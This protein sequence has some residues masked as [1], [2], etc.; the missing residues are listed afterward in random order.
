MRANAA[1][2]EVELYLERTTTNLYQWQQQ[3]R[4]CEKE[5]V[6]H[7]GPP[8]ANGPPHMGHVLNKVLKDIINRNQVLSG[9]RVQYIPGWDCHG[10]PIEL[11]A[12]KECRRTLEADGASKAA[13]ALEIREIARACALEAIGVQKE[14]FKRWG[15]MADWDLR[16]ASSPNIQKIYRTLDPEYEAMQLEVLASMVSRGCI[17]RGFRPVY[18][19]PSSR[20]ALAEA[21]LEYVDA[22]VSSAVHC[23]FRLRKSGNER[24]NSLVEQYPGVSVVIWTTTPW[25]LPANMA[26]CVHPSLSY[27]V[28]HVPDHDRYYMVAEELVD[29]FSVALEVGHMLASSH[30]RTVTQQRAELTADL[31]FSALASPVKICRHLFP[32]CRRGRMRSHRQWWRRCPARTSWGAP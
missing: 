12:L 10:L 11:K 8:Y 16:Y 15:V 7:D 29:D 2:R 25:T 21:E 28:L 27:V 4:Q 5:F 23:S 9:Y 13:V 19:S 24:W 20:T 3:R 17:Q 14:A 18:W 1:K 31:T 30:S 22:H 26:I 6:L 32:A